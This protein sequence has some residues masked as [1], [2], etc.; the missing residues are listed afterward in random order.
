MNNTIATIITSLTMA[1][2]LVGAYV[3]PILSSPLPTNVIDSDSSGFITPIEALEAHDIGRRDYASE[4][5]SCTEYYWL[6]DGLPAYDTCI[7]FQ[8]P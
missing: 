6:K 3:F 5:N 7:K 4:S 8:Q 1:S 2:I